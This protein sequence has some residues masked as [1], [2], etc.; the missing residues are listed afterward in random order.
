MAEQLPNWVY[1]LVN[2]LDEQTDHPE[3][4]FTSGAFEGTAKYEWCPCNALNRVPGAVKEQAR[5]IAA[6]RREAEKDK[7][8]GDV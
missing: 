8:P 3:L 7:E 1:D 2:E 6:Y 4:L 5:V